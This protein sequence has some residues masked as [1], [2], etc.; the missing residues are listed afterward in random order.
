MGDAFRGLTIRIGADVRPLNSAIS[1]IKSAAAG[2]TKQFN[3]MNKA[4]RF[5]SGN[6]AAMQMRLDLIGDKAMFAARSAQTIRTAMSQADSETKQLAA[7]TASVYAATQKARDGYNGVNRSLQQI[8]DAAAKVAEKTQGF[9]DKESVEWVKMLREAAQ[10]TGEAAEWAKTELKGLIEAAASATNVSKLF[11]QQ[12]GDAE[13]LVG[14]YERLREAHKKM[15]AQLD[16]ATDAEGFR[17]MK[18]QLI[19]WE[20]ELREA[21][22]EAAR[23]KAELFALGTGGHLA[24]SLNT[25][26]RMDAAVEQSTAHAR[27]MADTYK[28]IPKSAEAA[29]A[30]ISSM[31][32]AEETLNTQID[33]T[34]EALRAIMSDKAFDIQA[35]RSKEAY[36]NAVK[37]A[38]AYEDLDVK[39]RKA[40][41]AQDAINNEIDAMDNG[42]LEKSAERYAKL[43]QR[44]N[45]VANAIDRMRKHLASMEGDHAAASMVMQFRKLEA[46]LSGCV[47][48]LEALR[49]ESSKLRAAMNFGT[50][51]RELGYGLYSTLTP[52]IMIAGRYAIQAA[53]DIDSAYRDMRKTVNGTEEEFEHLKDAAL[54]FSTTHVT[55]ADTILEIEAMGGQLGIQARN[56]E[57][58][59]EVVSNL[60]IATD[61]DAEDMAKYIGQLSN[62][63]RDIDQS[64]P[65]Q[66][67]KDITAFSDALV[68]L[69]NNSAAQESSIMKVMMRIA[70][71]GN[72][73]GFTTPQLLAISTAVAAT[74]QGCEAA[75]T[76]ISKTFSNIEAA[77]GAGGDSL[78]AFA[79]IA[80]M[81]AE[82][83]AS[84]WEGDPI[85]AF[86]AFIGGLKQ[87]D[88]SGG[89]VD[90]TL[91]SLKI[92]SVRQKQ[93]LEG[94]VNTFDVLNESLGMS[95]T[96]WEGL[97]YAMQDGSGKVEHAGDAAREAKRKSEGFS[98]ELEMMKNNAK[99]LASELADGAVPIIKAMGE[100]FQQFTALAKSMPTELK[101]AAVGIAGFLAAIGPVG[102]ATGTITRSI[103]SI[104]SFAG[105]MQG[106]L[107]EAG[108]SLFWMAGSMTNS[109]GK[110]GAASKAVSGLGKAIQFLGS[111]GGMLATAGIAVGI[112][113]IVGA[114]QD[115][116]KKQ[117]DFRKATD[118][119]HDATTRAVGVLST[120]TGKYS[121]VGGAARSSAKSVDELVESSVKLADTM[122]ERA[123][124]TE[125]EINNLRDAQRIINRYTNHDLSDNI[126]AQ[127]Q[128]KAAIDLVN[129]ACGTQYQVVD[130]VNGRIADEKGQLLETVDAINAYITAKVK[131]VEMDQLIADRADMKQ[132]LEDD[133]VAYAEAAKT[134]HDYE[135]RLA[136]ARRDGIQLSDDEMAALVAAEREYRAKG[137]LMRAH[138]A[139]YDAL[140]ERLGAVV[141]SSDKATVS[142]DSLARAD[143][144]LAGFFS[145]DA[146]GFEDFRRQLDDCGLTM[147]DF[148]NITAE[149]WAN[150]LA[151]WASGNTNLASILDDVGVKTRTLT[152]Q[153]KTEFADAGA[154]FDEFAAHA[155]TSAEALAEALHNS[156]ASASEMSHMG[157]EA[158]D[159]LLRAA[160]GD[161][162]NIGVALDLLNQLNIDPKNI[163]F[164]DEGMIDT[165]SGKL[166]Q[167]DFD[168]DKATTP[169]TFRIEEDGTLTE[170][171]DELNDLDGKEAH[172]RVTV[173]GEEIDEEHEDWTEL[174][175]DVTG[176]AEGEINVE[177]NTEYA[178]R[179]VKEAYSYARAGAS[180]TI[181]VGLVDYASD[182]L[183]TILNMIRTINATSALVRVA[184]NAEGGVAVPSLIKAI[185]RNASGALNGI[186]ARPTLTNIGW[187]GEAGAEAILHMKNAGGAVIPLS[188]RQYVRP[189]ARAVAM[190][191]GGTG[192]TT[193][194]HNHYIDGVQVAPDSALANAMDRFFM[195]YESEMA[196]GRR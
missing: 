185:P 89:S 146:V 91:R 31:K 8:Y 65:A 94:L 88:E 27:Q 153:Y 36:I 23:F 70:S 155:G 48:K 174:E 171:T 140:N 142:L 190:E 119:V 172:S 144:V 143:G 28:L 51:L 5:D 2:A 4:L 192:D 73:S 62:I 159:N 6:V 37:V 97:D 40:K 76:A 116:I 29:R 96:A 58:F 11:N 149:Q 74:G 179:K 42:E 169:R 170:I 32:A 85:T 90:N 151:A 118:G 168:A 13:A 117:E 196:K 103:A 120:A 78:E 66:Y 81:S 92:N 99:V 110:L 164:T 46:E 121:S 59:A 177:A 107:V 79:Q 194:I 39:I 139:D 61:I 86:T 55:S 1:S 10:G 60:D 71:L 132:Q 9:T 135:K 145:S 17:A 19:A 83:F 69:G 47:G 160:N 187:V 45:N 195:Q 18:S 30:K 95:Q 152:D 44:A 162:S 26:K 84:A 175:D 126:T 98:G 148:G 38:Q 49:A 102:V 15:K 188:N 80:G 114:I 24:S 43:Q 104:I 189:F 137:E 75:G 64:N 115:A 181:S 54:D 157:I 111:T 53:A 147:A 130:L 191:M 34:R 93:A 72:I 112:S 16:M 178:D 167:L 184:Q 50:G 87:I 57:K 22:S 166:I 113:L 163:I 105:K 109:A 156:G 33:K 77:V 173:D 141:T 186:I 123:K 165:I 7:S 124:A 100:Q 134:Y 108:E 193:I 14:T 101:T 183:S 138:Q 161:I 133:A 129:E 131:Q 56:L 20:A 52:A 41:A 12:K 136:D 154:N 63:M 25:L 106:K 127:G 158:F 182:R 176:G 180:G 3:A 122:N 35:A 128:L 82:D 67:G 150:I 125:S 68:R 21:A